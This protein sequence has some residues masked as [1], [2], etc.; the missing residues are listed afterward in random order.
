MNSFNSG[1]GFLAIISSRRVLSPIVVSFDE[2][3]ISGIDEKED[4]MVDRF[5]DVQKE[6]GYRK[7][8]IPRHYPFE[9]STNSLTFTGILDDK[10]YVYIFLLLATRSNMNVYRQL[11]GVDGTLV[12]EELC[13]IALAKFFGPN[14]QSFLFGTSIQGTFESK[15]Q[16]LITRAGIGRRLENRGNNIAIQKDDGIDIV[17]YLDFHDKRDSKL[18][19]FGQCKTGVYWRD[20]IKKLDPE[21]FVDN[22][23]L[24]SPAF[25]PIKV[26]MISDVLTAQ[27]NLRK[28]LIDS[29]AL[30][31]TRFRIMEYLP[32]VIESEVIIKIKRWVDG[33]LSNFSL[34]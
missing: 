26:V 12:F 20:S 11:G 15:V 23:L 17:A 29:K 2:L 24:D 16:N 34:S 8:A 28:D 25:K 21:S 22:W 1:E 7:N 3:N 18:V 13:Q 27:N 19:A 30:F 14:S 6:L 33:R 31:F 32:E 10:N 5:I 4:E 9:I